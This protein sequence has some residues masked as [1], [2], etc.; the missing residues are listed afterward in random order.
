M[1]KLHIWSHVSLFTNEIRSQSILDINGNLLT[2]LL[3]FTP[4]VEL[5]QG[6]LCGIQT[7]GRQFQDT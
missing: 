6:T 1:V 3:I 7:T 2:E 5:Q 4:K